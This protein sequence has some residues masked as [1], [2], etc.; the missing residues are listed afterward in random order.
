MK[1]TTFEQFDVVSLITTKNV[2]WMID[3]PGRVPDP[4]GSW[5]I[6][7]TYPASGLL[8]LQ[9]GTAMIRVPASDV[10]KLANYNVQRVFDKLDTISKK[11]RQRE[12][13]E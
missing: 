10:R 1:R 4:D 12:P 11:Y 2:K 7:C 5:T 6:V 8:L 3:L 9:K 13:N